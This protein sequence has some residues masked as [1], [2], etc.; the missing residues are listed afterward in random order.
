MSPSWTDEICLSCGICCTTLSTVRI[1]PHDIERLM[2][3]YGLTLA[4][5]QRLVHQTDFTILMDKTAACPALSANQGRYRCNAY[6]HRP[7]ICRAYECYILEFAKEWVNRRKENKPIDERNAFYAVE[8]E[9]QLR[10]Q[11]RLCIERMRKDWLEL[12]LRHQDDPTFRR[13]AHL[14]KLLA[15]LSGANFENSFPPSDLN[16]AT[17]ERAGNTP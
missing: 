5:A 4:Q 3:G 2:R 7:D 16:T 9:D 8:T 17:Q 6:Q 10:E 15:T 14:P 13:P 1:Q 11:V 12:C